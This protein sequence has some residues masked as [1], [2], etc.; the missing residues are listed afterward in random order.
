M[1]EFRQLPINERRLADATQRAVDALGGLKVA[2]A[3]ATIK[4]SQIQRC[5]SKTHP[6]SISIRDAVR[7]DALGAD[8]AGHPHI[9]NTMADLIG[10]VVIMLPEAIGGASSLQT[11]VITLAVELG[12][13]SRSITDAFADSSAGGD[14]VTAREA[15]TVLQQ[16]G[17]LER[18]T[19]KF[20]HQLER[21][22]RADQPAEA[23]P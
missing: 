9:L 4:K 19:A 13:V 15:E 6:A 10:A 20:R 2:E 17:D 18:A 1:R 5:C 22:I 14:E 3:E 7:I 8:E 16:V 11:S 12:D 21:I 23:P